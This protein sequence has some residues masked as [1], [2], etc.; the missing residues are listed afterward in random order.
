MFNE[1]IV[2]RL[3]RIRDKGRA[4]N[5]NTYKKNLIGYALTRQ[6]QNVI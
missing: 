2:L 4:F 6:L 5:R 3:Q 1:M